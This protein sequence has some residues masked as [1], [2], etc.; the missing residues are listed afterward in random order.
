MRCRESFE[1]RS[2]CFR[3]LLLRVLAVSLTLALGGCPGKKL[4]LEPPTGAHRASSTES[5]EVLTWLSQSSQISSLRLMTSLKLSRG[6]KKDVVRQIVVC[7]RPDKL[8][9]EIFAPGLNQLLALFTAQNGQLRGF[10][11]SE[12]KFYY[13]KASPE[14]FE[15][16][17]TIPFLPDEMMLWLVGKFPARSI[18]PNTKLDVLVSPDG[19]SFYVRTIALEGRDVRILLNKEPGTELRMKQFSM[20][21]SANARAIFSSSF[22]YPFRESVIPNVVRFSLEDFDGEITIVQNSINTLPES[23]DAKL[24]NVIQPGSYRSVNLD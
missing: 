8:R 22:D 1:E 2:P 21:K 12:K 6:S 14:N 7:R 10:D 4:G 20:A 17:L 23:A 11:T 24:F 5:R 3:L 9:V 18:E 15:R 13:G 16:T 19:R